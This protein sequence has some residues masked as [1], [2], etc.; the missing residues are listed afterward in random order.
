LIRQHQLDAGLVKAYAA[1]Y[2]GTATLRDASRDLV[3]AFIND[4]AERASK[5]RDGLVCHLNSYRAQQEV[6]S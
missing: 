5:D 3:E 6:N 2:C 1:D 4:L